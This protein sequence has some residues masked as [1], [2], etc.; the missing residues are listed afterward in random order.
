MSSIKAVI[1]GFFLVCAALIILAL[2]LAALSAVATLWALLVPL[3]V[4]VMIAVGL[5]LFFTEDRS[6]PS[7]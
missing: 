6:P 3:F 4:V 1:K 7:E 5:W 2:V